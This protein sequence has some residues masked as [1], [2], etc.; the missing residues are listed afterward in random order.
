[1]QSDAERDDQEI[2]NY[3]SSESLLPINALRGV[4]DVVG[5]YPNGQP[6][7]SS[8]LFGIEGFVN[9]VTQSH[10]PAFHVEMT[11]DGFLIPHQYALA[12]HL[13][14]FPEYLSVFDDRHS[15]AE[16]IRLF[17][18]GCQAASFLNGNEFSPM[19]DSLHNPTIVH[20]EA[21][22][23][24]VTF[25][26]HACRL[27]SYRRD[28]YDRRYQAN[29]RAVAIEDYVRSLHS[30]YCRLNNVRLDL[31]YRDEYHGFI[32]IDD[33][34]VHL[35]SFLHALSVSPIFEHLC[36]YIWAIEQG[37]DKGYH[38]HVALFFLGW[39]VRRDIYKAN[40]AGELWRDV[41]TGGMGNFFN[42]NAKKDEYRYNG[43]GV[44]MRSDTE[45]IE[46]IVMALMYLAKDDGQHLR[47]KPFNR[48]V[49][50]TA[51]LPDLYGR[52]RNP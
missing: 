44:V 32:T 33:V 42:C 10:L 8:I 51:Q 31:S 23:R 24:L 35:M 21:M 43:L 52:G 40:Q 3:F 11:S 26:R 18:D 29:G 13:K 30:H 22:N 9:E 1:M 20:A 34:Y 41:F 27:N 48:H 4:R 36:G 39:E 50:G 15:Y 47:M 12:R 37:R 49:F 6:G 25:I 5:I 46:N 19:A 2:S 17:R 16:T 7:Q 45:K 38:I 28:I 14:Y